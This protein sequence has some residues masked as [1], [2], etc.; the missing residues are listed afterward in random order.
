MKMI[1][2]VLLAMLALADVQ[3]IFL[4]KT[5]KFPTGE[6]AVPINQDKDRAIRDKFYEMVC[7]KDPG[8]YRSYWSQLIFTGKGAPPKDAGDDAAVKE[9]IAKNP[10]LI[11]YIDEAKA[12]NSVKIVYRVK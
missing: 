6:Q 1:L 2:I 5:K 11:T 9:L 12:D 8:Q 7:N 10:N 3:R 4:G